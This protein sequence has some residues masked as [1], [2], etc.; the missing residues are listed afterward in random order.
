MTR[1]VHILKHLCKCATLAN[2][3]LLNFSLG[4]KVH[5]IR[6]GQQCIEHKIYNKVCLLF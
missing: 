2:W 5:Y 1:T 6:V 4:S 3:Q